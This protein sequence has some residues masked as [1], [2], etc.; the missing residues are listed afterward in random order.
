MK[1]L[2]GDNAIDAHPAE[3]N[4]VVRRF[5]TEFTFASITLCI[6]AL[7]GVVNMQPSTAARAAE[8]AR[9]QSLATSYRNTTHVA[10]SICGVCNQI[11]VPLEFRPRDITLM[12]VVD[13][14][15]PFLPIAAESVAHDPLATT[16]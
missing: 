13:Q 4:A 10:F 2:L 9:Q 5:D 15:L 3:A 8:Q 14:N 6:A 12:V 7:T 1:Y 11:L 16:F